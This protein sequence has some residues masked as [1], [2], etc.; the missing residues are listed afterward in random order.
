M[1]NRSGFTIVELL[2]VIVMIAILATISIVTYNGIQSRAEAAKVAVDLGT[3]NDAIQIYYAEKGVYPTT[4]GQWYGYSG[5]VQTTNY[6][7]GLTPSYI[8][9]L[10]QPK[11]KSPAFEYIYN[12]NGTDYKLIAHDG[13][14]GTSPG[15]AKICPYMPNNLK[16]P[17]RS[18]WAA[19]YWSQG[20]ASF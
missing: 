13:G 11:N 9:S 7:P 16:D 6:V 2:I 17:N 18:C 10:P 5:G 8:D 4:S 1:K 15:F 3:V 12:S 19:G 14:G 20:G